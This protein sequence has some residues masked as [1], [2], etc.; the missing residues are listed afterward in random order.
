[1]DGNCYIR[2]AKVP[3]FRLVVAVDHCFPL[4]GKGTVMTGTVID[5]TVRNPQVFSFTFFVFETQIQKAM[6]CTIAARG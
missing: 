5:G 4:T 3:I 6:G 1:M 2:L